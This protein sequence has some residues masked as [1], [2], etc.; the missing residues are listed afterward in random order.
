METFDGKVEP[1]A[2]TRTSN[3]HALTK[4]GSPA[5]LMPIDDS[6]CNFV[7]FAGGIEMGGDNDFD[8][9]PVTQ[10]NKVCGL[11]DYDA[12]QVIQGITGAYI[13][14]VEKKD[15][16]PLIN[17]QLVPLRYSVQPDYWEIQ[18]MGSR[19]G[20]VPPTSINTWPL[21]MGLDDTI[22]KKGILLVGATKAEKW[23][24]P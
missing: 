21:S 6:R 9:V 19:I 5:N 10:V 24:L 20:I 8:L 16:D 13:L 18:V 4:S 7:L 14:I 11:I 3:T 2:E 15:P 1:K 17:P 22:G 12:F 23:D